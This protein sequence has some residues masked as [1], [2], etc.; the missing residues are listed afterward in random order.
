M[1]KF[2]FTLFFLF[3][4]NF[5]NLNALDIKEVNYYEKVFEKGIYNEFLIMNRRF[6]KKK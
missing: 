6:Y 4:N 5:N 1:K 2:F 3:F